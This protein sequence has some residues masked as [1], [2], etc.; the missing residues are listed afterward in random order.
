V[1]LPNA[2]G[3]AVRGLDQE[4]RELLS[5]PHGLRTAMGDLL[6]I[7][8]RLAERGIVTISW[9]GC[10]AMIGT[11]PNLRLARLCDNMARS[12]VLVV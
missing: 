10:H 4:E 8:E 7:A 6:P 2:R 1:G 12:E 3:H 9:H 5:M 11:G